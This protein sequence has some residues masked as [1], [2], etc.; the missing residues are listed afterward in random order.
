MVTL[1]SAVHLMVLFILPG[2]ALILTSRFS[3]SSFARDWW[4]ARSSVLMTVVGST[5]IAFSPTPTV[6]AMSTSSLP[7]FLVPAILDANPSK[8][9]QA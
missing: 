6:M 7:P 1:D 3:L 8:F 5:G 9:Q 2:A 4:L